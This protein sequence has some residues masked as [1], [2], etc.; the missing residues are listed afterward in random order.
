MQGRSKGWVGEAGLDAP[1]RPSYAALRLRAP[2]SSP[3]FA[4]RGVKTLDQPRHR[5]RMLTD[6]RLRARVAVKHAVPALRFVR[7]VAEPGSVAGPE[8]MVGMGGAALAVPAPEI[9]SRCRAAAAGIVEH[10]RIDQSVI[11][12]LVGRRRRRVEAAALAREAEFLDHQW[13]ADPRRQL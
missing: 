8:M 3:S 9:G 12:I 11:T 2:T 6:D 1:V 7:W 5:G 4:G 13:L 10:H